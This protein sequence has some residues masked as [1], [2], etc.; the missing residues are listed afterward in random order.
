MND[1]KTEKLYAN[2]RIVDK[3]KGKNVYHQRDENNPG[4]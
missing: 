2:S 3:D 1:Q 4:N